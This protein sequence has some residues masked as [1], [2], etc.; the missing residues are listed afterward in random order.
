M[1][2]EPE[3]GLNGWEIG[4]SLRNPS[5]AIQAAYARP[6]F[7]LRRQCDGHTLLT[8]SSARVNS[9]CHEPGLSGGWLGAA[10]T[11]QLKEVE[12]ASVTS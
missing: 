4:R 6:Y 1:E 2:G 10:L 3:L 7:P 5:V 12:R 9:T 8:G 11:Q